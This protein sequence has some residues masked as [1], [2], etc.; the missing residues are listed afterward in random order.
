[1]LPG[2]PQDGVVRVAPVLRERG[3][4]RRRVVRAVAAGR[5]TAVFVRLRNPEL[6]PERHRFFRRDAEEAG[7][8][9]PVDRGV[10]QAQGEPPGAE[11]PGRV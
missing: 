11:A 3:A 5:S 2:T 7:A 6:R 4:L 10:R 8:E 1:M 9:A